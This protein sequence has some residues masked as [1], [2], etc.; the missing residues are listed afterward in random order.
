MV[1]SNT[2]SLC[3]A[4]L[5][6]CY[7]QCFHELLRAIGVYAVKVK[8]ANIGTVKAGYVSCSK[9]KQCCQ[10]CDKPSKHNKPIMGYAICPV[11]SLISLFIVLLIFCVSWV[12]AYVKFSFSTLKRIPL[13]GT[14]FLRRCPLCHVNHNRTFSAC[15]L[16]CSI[17]FAYNFISITSI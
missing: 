5:T 8:N 13:L 9:A 7:R 4:N 16:A 12:L 11:S 17:G 15:P 1:P 14:P 2:L 6:V 10:K 3:L